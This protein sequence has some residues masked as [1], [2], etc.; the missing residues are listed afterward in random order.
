MN[1]KEYADKETNTLEDWPILSKLV[2]LENIR[3]Y[4]NMEE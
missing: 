2:P 1:A 3:K 4:I